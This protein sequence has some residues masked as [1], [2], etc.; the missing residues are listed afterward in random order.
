MELRREFELIVLRFVSA[1]ESREVD[2]I[3]EGELWQI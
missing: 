1:M 3:P 2:L